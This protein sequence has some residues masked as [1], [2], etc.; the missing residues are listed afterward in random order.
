M[1]KTKYHN[2]KPGE[3]FNIPIEQKHGVALWQIKCCDCGL[4]HTVVLHPEKDLIQ[5]AVWRR[6]DL[7]NIELPKTGG[8]RGR[9]KRL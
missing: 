6:D 7:P 4:E 9:S 8:K 3:V 1:D 2:V 5:V